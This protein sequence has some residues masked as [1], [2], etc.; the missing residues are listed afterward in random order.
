MAKKLLVLGVVL[1]M[2]LGIFT[3]CGGNKNFVIGYDKIGTFGSKEVDGGTTYYTLAKAISVQELQT[4]C[5]E[6]GNYAFQENGDHY[7]S[8]LSQKI[9]SYDEAFFNDKV[10]V[11]YSFDRGHGKETRIDSIAVDGTTLIVNASYKIKKGTFTS[12]AFNWLILI[13]VSK[14]EVAGTTSVEVKHK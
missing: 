2:C 7:G 14:A 11:I 10:L 9:R 5:V 6:F 12:E 1:I 8:E 3:A 4:L 13:E